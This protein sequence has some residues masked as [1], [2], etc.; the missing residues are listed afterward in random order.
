MGCLWLLLVF[1]ASFGQT[2]NSKISSKSSSSGD[3][4]TISSRNDRS[5]YSSCS[6]RCNEKRED[7][8]PLFNNSDFFCAAIE[9]ERFWQIQLHVNEVNNSEVIA[10]LKESKS[11]GTAYRTRF[12]EDAEQQ[13]VPP[14][15]GE[16]IFLVVFSHTCPFSKKF[17][18][19]FARLSKAFPHI[20]FIRLDGTK[21]S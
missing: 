16:Y 19:V 20:K 6:G 21:V 3:T 4:I 11:L 18:P 15:M 5:R 1:T 12:A 10:L 13:I 9:L 17:M 2:R 7:I 8:S 14:L